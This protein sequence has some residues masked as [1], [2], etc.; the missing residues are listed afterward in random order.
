MRH[1]H[2]AG[3]HQL[4]NA[5]PEVF[6]DHRVYAHARRLEK[7]KHLGVRSVDGEGDVWCNVEGS[8]EGLESG[9]AG[10]VGGVAG[11]ADEDELRVAFDIISVSFLLLLL[12]PLQEQ[13]K[14]PQ[15]SGV[16]FLRPKLRN[17]EH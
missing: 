10:E 6:V 11:T 3:R 7:G 17:G 1:W 9:Y 13:C 16:V 8:G 15:L 12:I 4:H 14:R 5:D 2:D